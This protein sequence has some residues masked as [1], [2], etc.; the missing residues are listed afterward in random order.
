MFGVVFADTDNQVGLARSQQRH[1][2]QID[3][4]T[5]RSTDHVRELPNS[6]PLNLTPVNAIK[7]PVANAL[8]ASSCIGALC[9]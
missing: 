3:L 6:A 4:V 1:V 8:H 5:A 7:A 2:A 9:P